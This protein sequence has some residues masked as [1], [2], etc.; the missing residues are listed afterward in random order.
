MFVLGFAVYVAGQI[1]LNCTSQP[2]SRLG[3]ELLSDHGVDAVDTRAGFAGACRRLSR[4]IGAGGSAERVLTSK[5][6]VET[7][8]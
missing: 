4:H 6:C 5:L 8:S 1:R 2:T 7:E 3:P